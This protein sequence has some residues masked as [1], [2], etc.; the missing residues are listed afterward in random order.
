MGA[1]AVLHPEDC[2]RKQP[3]T[4]T[5]PPRNPNRSNHVIRSPTENN[6]K[7]RQTMVN[8]FPAKNLVMGQV[9]ILK[10]GEELTVMKNRGSE[11]SPKKDDKDFDDLVLSSISRLGPE[12]EMVP[13]QSRLGDLYAG[14]GFVASPPPSSLPLPAFLS[15]KK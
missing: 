7:S 13:K 15:K 12:P 14:L 5:K 3:Q 2:L 1:M 10:R 11:K 9:K 8:N 4:L 6:N